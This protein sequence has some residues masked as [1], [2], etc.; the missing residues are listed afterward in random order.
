MTKGSFTSDTALLTAEG[1]C[2]AKLL[3]LVQRNVTGKWRK[4]MHN[5]NRPSTTLR[6]HILAQLSVLY[7]ERLR[8]DL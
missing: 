5:W 2:V 3:Y 7:E 4:P 6:N 8:L 1:S